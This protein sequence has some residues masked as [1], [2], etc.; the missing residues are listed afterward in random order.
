VLGDGAGDLC[1]GHLLEGVGAAN[2]VGDLARYGDQGA[3]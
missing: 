1:N 2:V 3:E